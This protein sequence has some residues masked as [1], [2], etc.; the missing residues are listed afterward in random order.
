MP[1]SQGSDV[2]V[3]AETPGFPLRQHLC[4]Q[5]AVV[6]R[7]KRNFSDLIDEHM[8]GSDFLPKSDDITRTGSLC[9]HCNLSL[10]P[11]K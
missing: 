7:N 3:P 6:L 8:A 11:T 1:Q 2:L 4:W 5:S 9:T 10:S